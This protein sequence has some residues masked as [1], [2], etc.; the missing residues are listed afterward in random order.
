MDGDDPVTTLG[1]GLPPQITLLLDRIEALEERVAELMKR[2]E[3]CER[4]L[5][6]GRGRTTPPVRT[7]AQSTCIFEVKE[8]RAWCQTHGWNCPDL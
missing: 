6:Y 3:A 4:D 1:Q 2:I 7:M 8:G 5:D